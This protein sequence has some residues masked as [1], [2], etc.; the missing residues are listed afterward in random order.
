MTQHGVFFCLLIFVYLFSAKWKKWL[1]ATLA[2]HMGHTSSPKSHVS[3]AILIRLLLAMAME[4]CDRGCGP[5]RPNVTVFGILGQVVN[6]TSPWG[7]GP[8]QN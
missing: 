7:K 3:I 1:E 8:S 6:T 5:F 2:A 4:V